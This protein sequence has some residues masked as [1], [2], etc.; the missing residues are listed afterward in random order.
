VDIPIKVLDY[1][2]RLLAGSNLKELSLVRTISFDP[3]QK[4][5]LSSIPHLLSTCT[6]LHS[7]YLQNNELGIDFCHQLCQGL[8]LNSPRGQLKSLNVNHN[9]LGSKGVVLLCEAIK[10]HPSLESLFLNDNG[11][12]SDGAIALSKV[13]AIPE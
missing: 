6:S 10:D 7:L 1:L 5:D 3:I 9:R 12:D 2:L 11:I 8:I 4:E 13:L